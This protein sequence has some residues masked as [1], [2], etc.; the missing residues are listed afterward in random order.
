MTNHVDVIVLSRGASEL[1]EVVR[2]GI[3]AQQGVSLT[4]HRVIGS[5]SAGDT[6]RWATIARA[7]NLGKRCGSAPWVLFVDDD[8]ILDSGCVW[9]LLEALRG[10]PSFA[11]LAADYLGEMAAQPATWDYPWHVAMGATL[12]RRD[13]LVLVNF[14][15]EPG[16]CECRCACDDLRRAGFG[17]GY[18]PEAKA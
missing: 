4:L 6:N 10:R 13:R 14:R 8:V 1:S 17:V 2:R 12:F 9:E 15:W 11:A 5:P 3:S 16:K 7:R 18:L